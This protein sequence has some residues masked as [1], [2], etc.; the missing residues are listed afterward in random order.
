MKTL[1]K[2]IYNVLPAGGVTAPRGF[3]AAGLHA[4][5]KRKRLDVGLLYSEVPAAAAGVFTTSLV[6]AAC[7]D[8][9]E[10]QLKA[11]P[12]LQ[13]ILVNSGNANACTGMQG[14]QD[15]LEMRNRAA[16]ALG[17]CKEAVAIASTGVIGVPL[18]MEKLNNGI[19]Q[20]AQQLNLMGGDDFARAIL[21]TDTFV[22]EI[23]MQL[24]IDDKL[25]TI[26]GVA[27]G[28]GMIHPNMATMLAFV[29]TEAAIEPAALKRLLGNVTDRTYN[30]ITVDGDTSTNDMVLVMANGL[31]GNDV[32]SEAHPQWNEFAEA[33][34]FAS[35]KLA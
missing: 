17:V 16:R 24:T 13:A 18:P 14:A 11:L 20:V 21:T 10:E 35:E 34:R 27:K 2:A 6:R 31:A 33:F 15:A 28:S 3:K 29:T 4:G 1:E 25:I 8:Q 9:N 19:A 23:A 22:K 32:L 26:G 30:R 7:V 5:I 12:Y